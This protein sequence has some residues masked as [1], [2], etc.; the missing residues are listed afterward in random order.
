MMRNAINLPDKLGAG[1][2]GNLGKFSNDHIPFQ[3]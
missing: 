2:F 3:L 1:L